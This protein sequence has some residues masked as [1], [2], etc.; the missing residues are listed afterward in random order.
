MYDI[1][2]NNNN[3]KRPFWELG[4]RFLP[5]CAPRSTAFSSPPSPAFQPFISPLLLIS[6]S[7]HQ[8]QPHTPPNG[9]CRRAQSWL[10]VH[11]E[12]RINAAV[13]PMPQKS[14]VMQAT[15]CVCVCV[16]VLTRIPAH[17]RRRVSSPLSPKFEHPELTNTNICSII[18]RS[19]L[20]L[21]LEVQLLVSLLRSFA[22]AALSGKRENKDS[23]Q[24]F[25]FFFFFPSQLSDTNKYKSQP[26]F[27]SRQII[28]NVQ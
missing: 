23:H 14:S 15:V 17:G 13:A 22:V 25:F 24:T 9:V 21:T 4:C 2:H 16:R 6:I 10:S 28:W 1:T 3:I 7:P 26:L 18:E 20:S 11:S 27:I 12:L 19:R 8:T 5:A